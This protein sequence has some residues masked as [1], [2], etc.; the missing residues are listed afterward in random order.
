LVTAKDLNFKDATQEKINY[1]ANQ[2]KKSEKEEKVD[3]STH[4]R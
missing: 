1:S 2:E 4:G 3:D